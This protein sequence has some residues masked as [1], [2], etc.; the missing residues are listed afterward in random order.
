MRIEFLERLSKY[1]YVGLLLGICIL[2]FLVLSSFVQPQYDDFSVWAVLDTNNYFE[3]QSYW[4]NQWTGRYTAHALMGLLHPI[5]YN[6]LSMLGWV[7]VIVQAA[8]FLSLFY[9]IKNIL[10][11][12][13]SLIDTFL[14]YSSLLLVFIWQIPSPAEAF[15]WIPATF[16]Y[17]LGLIL[18]FLFFGLL[19]GNIS[20][21]TK[22]QLIILGFLACLI[23]GTSEIDLLIFAALLFSTVVYQYFKEKSLPQNLIILLV[24]AAVFSLVSILAPGNSAR[25]EAI[26]SIEGAQPGNIGFTIVAAIKI[27][28]GQL[29]PLFLKSPLLILS[30]LFV[31]FISRLNWN[32]NSVIRF[33]H[34]VAYQLI[35]LGLY[36]FLHLPFI[37]KAGI[38]YMPGRVLNVTQLVFV[39]GWFGLLAILVN[40]HQVTREK[41]SYLSFF[42][43]V[44]T[45]FYIVIQ[46]VLPNKIQS[47]IRDYTS[48]SASNYKSVMNRR[49]A[50]F[51]KSKGEDVV[52]EPLK[53]IPYTIFIADVT[54]NPDE[55]RNKLVSMYFSLESI[56][57]DS[58]LLGD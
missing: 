21:L 10:P 48:G 56:K 4:Y 41:N 55:D 6:N 50:L 40:Y 3:A 30:I 15:Y 47:A 7:S 37:F 19:W 9:L 39:A 22:K 26:Q 28:K 17:Q 52:V 25:S 27:I 44:I 58:T 57:S 5:V 24:I 45:T 33:W 29:L 18:I 14:V 13:S 20:N 1:S 54:D 38:E 46:L 16:S 12:K 34:L 31:W 23:P 53:N 11:I 51:E 36:F 42:F 43:F 2:P 35:W 32:T 49:Y 8:F